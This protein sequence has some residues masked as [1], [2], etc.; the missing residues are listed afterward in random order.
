[1]IQIHERH[2]PD[3]HEYLR[4]ARKMTRATGIV[5]L[6]RVGLTRWTDRSTAYGNTGFQGPAAV[7]AARAG[8]EIQRQCY[9]DFGSPLSG[10]RTW[11]F[12]HDEFVIHGHKSLDVEAAKARLCEIMINKMQ[13]VTPD[14][15]VKVEAWDGYHWSK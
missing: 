8:I 11:A 15:K 14:V 7:G 12:I 3:V 9:L 5:S 4:W 1:M 6:P 13:E 10:W 2:F